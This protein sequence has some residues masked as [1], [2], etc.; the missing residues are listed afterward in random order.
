[1]KNQKFVFTV[2]AV[3]FVLGVFVLFFFG[4]KSGFFAKVGTV[5]LIPKQNVAVVNPGVASNVVVDHII[6]D[7]RD[8]VDEVALNAVNSVVN[9]VRMIKTVEPKVPS[10]GALVAV[11]N[12]VDLSRQVAIV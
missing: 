5:S 7:V 11:P 3:L 9:N 6:G 4:F 1:M 10:V 12:M 2:A 8:E